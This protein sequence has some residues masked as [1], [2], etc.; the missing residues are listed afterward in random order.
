[1]SRSMSGG[2][3]RPGERNRSKSMRWRT[4]STAVIPRAKQTAEFAADP[5]PW[6][7]IPLRLQKATISSTMRKYPGK[8]RA[9]MRP[10]SWSTAS[11]ARGL[12]A[13]VP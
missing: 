3:E 9:T 8:S 1:M 13:R 5:R 10:S 12:P 11:H 2:P 4:A 6:H 7:Q